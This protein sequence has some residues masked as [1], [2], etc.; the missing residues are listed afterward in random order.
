[1]TE[2]R[3]VLKDK[4]LIMVVGPVAIGK[5]TL[6]RAVAELN[7]NFS[8]VTSFTTR[9]QRAGEPS[10]YRHISN[11]QATE[12]E[13]TGR[14]VTFFRH[15]TTGYIYGTDAES[16][17]TRFNLLDTLSA[18]VETYRQLP[19]ERTVT[20]SLTTDA[21]TWQKWLDSRYP[22]PSDERTKRL[23]EAI[24]SI[25]WSLSQTV[26]HHWIIN[27]AGGLQQSAAALIATIKDFESAGDIPPQAHELLKRA[28]R[29]LSYEKKETM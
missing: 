27:R 8:Y 22:E 21:D 17:R 28:K 4:T 26:G 6:M 25:E 15:P 2:A 10:S 11:E 3:E 20:I 12:L 19:F 24:M 14:A 9:P 1:M 5:S 18:A 13:A 16:Y 7:P 29:L 23:E